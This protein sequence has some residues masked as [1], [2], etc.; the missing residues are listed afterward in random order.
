MKAI[1]LKLTAGLQINIIEHAIWEGA[2]VVMYSLLDT[3][4]CD[5]FFSYVYQKDAVCCRILVS[6]EY[7]GFCTLEYLIEEY[8][9]PE[10]SA[11]NSGRKLMPLM[12]VHEKSE[13]RGKPSGNSESSM[14]GTISSKSQTTYA[15]L[16][17]IEPR[18]NSLGLFS[19]RSAGVVIVPDCHCEVIYIDLFAV[20]CYP[21]LDFSLCS[22]YVSYTSLFLGLLPIVGEV[23]TCHVLR[24]S[25]SWPGN[26]A[27]Q[28]TITTVPS[29]IPTWNVTKSLQ[30]VSGNQ[31]RSNCTQFK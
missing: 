9:E 28:K 4:D 21:P 30:A 14:S 31:Y 17:S 5:D 13:L 6:G 8:G 10:E 23:L 25:Y 12:P 1:S 20:P 29:A 15:K 26:S 19:L 3:P 27:V 11:S 18:R 2:A 22:Q 24:F 16:G 7:F